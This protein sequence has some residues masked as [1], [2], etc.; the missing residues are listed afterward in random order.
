MVRLQNA[1]GG[2]SASREAKR[3]AKRF[4]RIAGR[5]TEIFEQ[6]APGNIAPRVAV[7]MARERM[8]LAAQ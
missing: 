2:L 3:A 1:E 8:G 4:E 6:S 5:L 7:S